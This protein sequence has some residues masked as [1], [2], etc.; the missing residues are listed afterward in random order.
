VFYLM[1]KSP[2]I[3]LSLVLLV[4]LVSRAA[5]YSMTLSN[6]HLCC[7]NCVSDANDA[8][9]PVTGA[10]AAADKASH[11]IKITASSPAAAQKAVD[12]LTAAGFYGES[13]DPKIH[14][15]AMSAPDATVQSLKLS[16]VHLCCNKCVSSINEVLAKVHGVTKTTAAKDVDSFEIQGNFN[17]QEVAKALNVAGFTARVE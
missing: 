11:S 16:G 4:P 2:L 7:S 5:D 10:V 1:I 15:T 8:V 17:P 3:L 13:S 14:V 6:V 9:K 12:A